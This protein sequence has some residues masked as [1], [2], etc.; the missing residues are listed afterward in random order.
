MGLKG[1]LAFWEA[2]DFGVDLIDLTVGGLFDQR[3]DETPDAEAIVYNYPEL[4]LDFRWTYGEY[5]DRVET[6]AKGLIAIG[7]AKGEH[8]AVWAPNL[9]EW[10][11][12]E[13]ALAQ[14]GA[15]LVTANTNYRSS[16]IEYL[17][18]Q[19]DVSV[20]FMV[21]EF[22]G[23]SFVDAISEIVPPRLRHVVLISKTPHPGR[24][25]FD[26]V[27]ALGD[28]VSDEEL[29]QR[30]AAVD[31]HDVAQIQYTSGTTGF[32]KGVMITHYALVNQARV[33]VL[34]GG[35]NRNERAISAMPLFHV[36]GC[37]GAVIY[38]IY[39]GCA[40]IELIAFDPLK[41]LELIQKEKATFTFAVPTMLIAMLNHPRFS[42]FDLS[43][44]RIIFTGATPVPVALMEQL[45]QKLGAD[46]MI[47]FG[48]TETTGAVTQSFP[49]DS[50]E[51]KAATVGLPQ[52]H[53]SIRII[54]PQSGET[55]RTGESGELVS[56]AF[57]NMNGY[58]NMPERTAESID[59]DG[60]L[61]SGDL[62]VM[63]SDGYLN[64]VG[65]VKDMII[66][67]GENIY[68]AEIE[69]FLMR[70]A[71]IAE[72]QV[73]GI[74]DDFMGEEVA[75]AIRLRPGAALTEQEV[76]DFCR[77]GIGRHKNPKLICFVDSFPLTA[78]GKVKKFEL[79]EQIIRDLPGSA[80]L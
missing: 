50:F 74:P 76:R 6:L 47:V 19:G 71:A 40:L 64:I 44:L 25:L 68:P 69:A 55:A 79:R 33:S 63:R 7:I 17:L 1:A 14:I 42:E 39:L 21:T 3:C 37:L 20:L 32:P 10:I 12:L 59:E 16:E 77:E 2:E 66:R 56:R 67:G 45:K 38:T 51:L 13:M 54:N 72:V 75:A 58:Y 61:H 31:T 57:S 53:T 41:K 36:A 23:N 24:L 11:L 43:S 49:G 5:R 29:R 8:V 35:L 27:L 78:S 65:R 26:D 80:G 4:G 15:V 28:R 60:W 22:R 18:R 73:V 70:H 9:P 48:M 30:K 62:A 52:P 34:R 46:C